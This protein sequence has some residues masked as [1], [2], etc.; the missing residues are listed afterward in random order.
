MDELHDLGLQLNFLS[1]CYRTFYHKLYKPD[2]KMFI[3]NLNYQQ[4]KLKF[5]FVYTQIERVSE[6][7]I[8]GW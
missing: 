7:A 5:V 6:M 1:F 8:Q 2:V 3:M 4:D